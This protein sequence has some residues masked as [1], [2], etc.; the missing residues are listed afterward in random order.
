VSFA[1][2]CIS[3]SATL[4]AVTFP[5]FSTTC[6]CTGRPLSL[7]PKTLDPLR[8]L[9]AMRVA[10]EKLSAKEILNQYRKLSLAAFKGLSE[11]HQLWH[12]SQLLSIQVRAC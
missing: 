2:G 10:K 8:F 6:A 12:G 11:E 4:Q 1:R 7:E 3:S 5:S 9:D